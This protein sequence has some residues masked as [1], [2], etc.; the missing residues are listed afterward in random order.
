MNFFLLLAIAHLL[1]D[2][3]FQTNWIYRQKFRSLP[4]GLWHAG[5]LFLCFLAILS[6]YL[7]NW[8]VIA[9]IATISFMH[10]FQDCL[11]IEI[12]DRRKKVTAFHGLLLDQFFHFLFLAVAAC[13]VNSMQ[14]K[15]F[16]SWIA[17]N[18]HFRFA[19]IYFV[20]LLLI[21]FV[22]NVIRHS[23]RGDKILRRDWRG[24]FIRGGIV[25][26]IF[27]VVWLVA[28]FIHFV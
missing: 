28:A 23:R 13:W 11:K 6:P 24:I 9:L 27:G 19:L 1:G 12:V 25:T 4:G 5:I 17:E 14:L 8:Q 22:W 7:A 21:T 2:F 15:I 20:A 16:F 10:Y 26:F 3:L 18:P